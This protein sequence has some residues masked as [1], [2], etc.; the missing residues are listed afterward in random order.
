MIVQVLPE[1]LQGLE[2]IEVVQEVPVQTVSSK[3]EVRPVRGL[4]WNA[5]FKGVSVATGLL[6][7]TGA[8]LLALHQ[9]K[10]KREIKHSDLPTVPG[11]QLEHFVG[12][13]YEIAKFPHGQKKKERKVGV[14]V[15]YQVMDPLTLKENCIYQ[16]GDFESKIIESTSTLHLVD[17]QNT[18][19]MQKQRGGMTSNPLRMNY[20][21]IEVG[22]NYNYAVI[23]TPDRQHLWILSR[24]QNFGPEKY[25]AVTHR[26]KQLGFAVENLVRV[27]HHGITPS[28]PAR[29]VI[30]SEIQERNTPQSP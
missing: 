19:R 2:N 21:V 15:H 25:E 12:S 23:G 8:A 22:E 17:P 1:D 3:E 9:L 20:W 11:F 13:W 6:S 24:S 18:A 16:E 26:M 7:L 10:L 30:Q 14:M 28:A 5:V 29:P 4:P 27:P